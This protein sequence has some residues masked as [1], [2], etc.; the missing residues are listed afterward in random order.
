MYSEAEQIKQI[1][2]GAQR[3]VIIQADNPDAD[4]LGSA[5]AMEH[6]LGDLGKEPFLYCGVDMPQYLRYMSGWDR[7]S[8][9]LPAQF[10]ASIIVDAS[11][12]TLLEKLVA[13]GHQSWFATKPCVVID[14]HEITDNPIPFATVVVNDGKR[15][16]AGELIFLLA[17][18]LGWSVSVDAKEKLMSSILGDTQG[19]TNQLASAETYRVMADFVEAGVDRPALE[20]IRRAFGKMPREIYLYKAKLISRTE[21]AAT[22]RIATVTIPQAEIN[23]F[24]P[25]YNPGPLIQGDM[26]QTTDVEVA[27]VF[28]HYADGKI[29][30]A[31]RCN[32]QA[33]I[34]GK[35]AEHFGGGGHAFASGFKITDG[36]AME[37]LKQSCLDYATELLTNL[38]AESNP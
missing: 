16:S 37:V 1:I 29:T 17:Q 10:D 25:L 31:I 8:D 23:E 33:P 11:T 22:G 19:L 3:I 21:F 13:S 24:S 7:V 36:R 9:E 26:L 15:A 38:N 6:I 14:H 18:Q 5:L 4:S 12:M 28:K 34:A 27:I 20:E 30:A 2:D 32:S 35:L